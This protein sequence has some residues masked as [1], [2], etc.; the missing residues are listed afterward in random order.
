MISHSIYIV[1]IL[2]AYHFNQ[3]GNYVGNGALQLPQQ[4]GAAS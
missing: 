3:E 1:C 2:L 4:L